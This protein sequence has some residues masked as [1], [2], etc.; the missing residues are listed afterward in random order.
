MLPSDQK[1]STDFIK[2]VF[3]DLDFSK[4]IVRIKVICGR[5]T[6]IRSLALDIA[7]EL[8]TV[9]YL[10][11]LIRTRLGHYDKNISINIEDFTKWISARN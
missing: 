7:H 2:E 8:G 6:Y 9:G 3:K 10:A 5:G 11:K 1:P 4:D